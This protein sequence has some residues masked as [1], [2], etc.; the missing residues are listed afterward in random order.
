MSH[1]SEGGEG[2]AADPRQKTLSNFLVAE[3]A[4]RRG[5]GAQAQSESTM[6]DD[7]LAIGRESSLCSDIHEPSRSIDFADTYQ[8]RDSVHTGTRHFHNEAE[9]QETSN[10]QIDNLNEKVHILIWSCS[11]Y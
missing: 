9:T 6:S 7:A 10:I 5:L 8:I 2:V 1:F 4:S 3:D 11:E